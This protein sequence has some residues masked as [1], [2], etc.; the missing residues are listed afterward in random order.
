MTPSALLAVD[1]RVEAELVR[2]LYREALFGIIATASVATMMAIVMANAMHPG[3]V[4]GWW[5]LTLVLCAGRYWLVHAFRRALSPDE[6][7]RWWAHRF[8]IGA[9]TS[10]LCWGSAGWIFFDVGGEVYRSLLIMVILGMT[11][12]GTRVLSPW[13]PAN[14]AFLLSALFPLMGRCALVGNPVAGTMAVVI[15]VYTGFLLIT[16]RQYNAGL[17]H[18]LRLGFENEGPRPPARPKAIFWP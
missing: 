1:R 11:A 13:L 12:G 18:A 4:A 6:Q 5:A 8:T 17:R 7:I 9:L 14:R 16:G 2:V 10:G 3:L 15:A